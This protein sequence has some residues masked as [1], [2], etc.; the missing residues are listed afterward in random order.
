MTIIQNAVTPNYIHTHAQYVISD[1]ILQ[2]SGSLLCHRES[3]LQQ[4][5]I[6]LA[7]N[8]RKSET[9]KLNFTKVPNGSYTTTIVN[10]IDPDWPSWLIMHQFKILSFSISLSD[11]PFIRVTSHVCWIN[12][13]CFRR[14][15]HV[16]NIIF[17]GSVSNS[18]KRRPQNIF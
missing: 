1:I 7:I 16:P 8:L 3:V 6:E 5:L 18:K 13:F 2:S 11:R 14:N 4:F 15:C 17:G 9:T 12:Q 10:S